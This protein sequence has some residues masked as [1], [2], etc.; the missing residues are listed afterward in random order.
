VPQARDSI[1]DFN[2]DGMADF[3]AVKA[4]S[5]ALLFYPREQVTG[6]RGWFPNVPIQVGTGYGNTTSTLKYAQMF[7]AGDLNGD[8]LPDLVGMT[9]TGALWL[10]PGNCTGSVGTPVSMNSSVT[11]SIG[12]GDFNG[13]GIADVLDRHSD[14]TLWLLAGTGTGTLS[15]P[16]HIGSDWNAFDSIVAAGDMN[17][18]GHPDV[19][20]RESNGT[21]LLY[22]GN[23]SGGWNAATESGGLKLSPSLPTSQDPTLVG[24]GDLD[25]DNTVD[26]AAIDS[27][28]ELVSYPGTGAGALGTTATQIGGGWDPSDL[29]EIVR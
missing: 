26:L 11:A 15:A 6:T 20:G 1:D 4:G 5:G 16:K 19:I 27:T 14:G 23:G 25:G 13:D 3:M 21:L 8:G 22:E 9:S 17:G 24:A 7:F 18:D 12:V 29:D 2:C 28:G 10:L